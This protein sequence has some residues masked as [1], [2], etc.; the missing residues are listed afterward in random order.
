MLKDLLPYREKSEATYASKGFRGLN[1]AGKLKFAGILFGNNRKLKDFERE[2]IRLKECYIG[3]FIGEFGN[4]LLHMLPFLG[5]LHKNGINIHYCGMTNQTPFLV[6]DKGSSLLKSFV[7]LRD[8]FH[9]VRPSGNSIEYLPKDIDIL[10]KKFQKQ[11]IQSRLPFLDIF[12]NSNLYW[13]SFRN[14]QLKGKQNIYNL[15]KVYGKEY[16][17]NKLVIFPRKMNTEFTL[18]NGGIWDYIKISKML[19]CH[20]DEIVFVGHPS[21]SDDLSDAVNDKVKLE[22]STDNTNVLKHCSTAKLIITQHSGAMHVSGYTHSP[23]LL[24]FNGNP[25]IK[26][27]DDSIRFRENFPYKEV[28]IVFNY[29]QIVSFCTKLTYE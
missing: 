13:Y 6:D 4:F 10:V 29:D 16:K 27:L 8:F 11:A 5:Y 19:S 28:S 12:S 23:V 1:L 26:G 9:E 3:P 17:K 22:L 18:N 2:S 15:S 25:P 24:I 21:M 20:F 7:E 14:W